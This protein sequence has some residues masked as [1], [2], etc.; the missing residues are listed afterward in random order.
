MKLISAEKVNPDFE[1]GRGTEAELTAE[2]FFLPLTGR[3]V[4][5]CSTAH[6]STFSIIVRMGEKDN[7]N[8]S[9]TSCAEHIL[10]KPAGAGP[11]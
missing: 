4:L 11:L 9:P 6:H 10:L 8:C 3:V 7:T 1:K 2:T 5:I